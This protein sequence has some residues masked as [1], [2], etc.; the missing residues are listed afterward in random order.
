[1]LYDNAQLVPLYLKAALYASPREHARFTRIAR[2]TLDYLHREMRS[3]EGLYYSA[4]DADSLA[5]GED[6][7]EEG[8]FLK[9]SEEEL[10]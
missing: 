1:M 6:H 3:P 10:L 5:P 8:L 4:T 2:E 7:P 9:D